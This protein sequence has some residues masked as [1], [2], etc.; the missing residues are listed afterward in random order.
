MPDK[1]QVLLHCPFCR[2][3]NLQMRF[4]RERWK[5]EHRCTNATCPWP[6]RALP[7]YVV[8]QEIFRFLPTVVVGTLDKAASIGLQQA[9]RG[10]VGPPQKVCSEPWH[11]FTYAE[12]STTPNGCLVPNC[13]GG[14][15]LKPLPM[16]PKRFGPSL[17]LQDELHL[18]RDSLGAVDSHYESLLDHLQHELCGTRAKIVASS[19]TLTGYDRQVEVLYRREGASVPAARP[20]GG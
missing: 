16:D 8:D 5:L 18:L 11:G 12:R 15:A 1:Y 17:R 14:K 2:D 10:L 3:E 6:G 13:Q 20:A 19:A 4:D 7:L 9:M